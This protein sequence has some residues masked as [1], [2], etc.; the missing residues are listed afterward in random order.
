MPF[1]LENNGR[2]HGYYNIVYLEMH[3]SIAHVSSFNKPFLYSCVQKREATHKASISNTK[4]H[5]TKT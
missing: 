1:K 4:V 3:L 5:L 2:I